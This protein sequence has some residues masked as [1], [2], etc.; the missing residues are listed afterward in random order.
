MNLR[1]TLRFCAC[2]PNPCRRAIP[3]DLPEQFETDTP[4]ALSMIALAVLEGR[5][6]P[7]PAVRRALARTS[8]ARACRPACPYGYDI[9]GMLEQLFP[10]EGVSA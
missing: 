2:C 4:S 9:A 10:G 7:Q 1:E 6:D 8:A 3:A 5:L